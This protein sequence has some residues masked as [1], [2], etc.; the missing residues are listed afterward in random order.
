MVLKMNNNRN[1]VS[2]IVV[3]IASLLQGLVL[4]R[5]IIDSFGS[6]VNGLVS[7]ITQFLS[8]I[9]LLEGGLGAV[10]LAELYKPIEDNDNLSVQIILIQCRSFFKK[11]SLIFIV[12]TITLSILYPVFFDDNFSFAYISSLIIILSISTL[13]QY[14]FSITNRLLLQAQQR[15]YI[16]NMV[17]AIVITINVIISAI[18]IRNVSSIHVVK[19]VS[20]SIF[21]IQP[22]IYSRIIESKYKME[23]PEHLLLNDKY[24]RKRWSGFAQ[25][26]AHFANMNTDIVLITIFFGYNDVSVYAVY[27][28]AINALRNIVTNVSNSYQSALGKYYASGNE[29]DLEIAFGKYETAFCIVGI[30]FFCTCLLLINPFVSLYTININDVNYYRPIF[31]LVMVLANL[32]YCV[33]EPYRA[34]VLAA[35]KFEETKFGSVMEAVIN[36]VLSILLVSFFGLVGLAMGTFIAVTYRFFYLVIFLRKNIIF[37]SFRSYRKL[38]VPSTVIIII[39]AYLYFSCSLDL[40]DFN[41]F[42]VW[43]TILFMLEFIISFICIG[44][45]SIKRQWV[46]FTK[47]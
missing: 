25:N 29:K 22:M 26:L 11:L 18:I 39:N 13:S 2:A 4:P 37:K 30:S 34:L 12:Y 9:T 38:I 32:I 21:L 5:L 14:L 45:L 46:P 19:V 33:R 42:I 15:I 16:V 44:D 1:F 43:G 24:L 23:V 7:S 47:N 40:Q 10:V 31:A 27:M 28:L 8:F 41:L 35:G 6:N 17:S 36:I 20:S 3:Q